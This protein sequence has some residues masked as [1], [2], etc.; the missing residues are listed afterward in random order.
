[1][2]L[3]SFCKHNICANSTFSFWGARL[4]PN[5]GKVMI[6]P[7]VHKNSQVFE[8]ERMYELWQGWTFIDRAGEIF[9][10]EER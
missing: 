3:M 7:A 1:M 5:D 2:Q 4:N 9:A 10:R 8:P 6:R